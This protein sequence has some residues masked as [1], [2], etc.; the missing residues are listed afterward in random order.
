MNEL[1]SVLARRDNDAARLRE[2]RDQHHSELVELRQ[3]D[4]IK[5]NSVNESKALAESRSVSLV[6]QLCTVF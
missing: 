3:R 4:T 6:I 5:F 2:Q 1:R